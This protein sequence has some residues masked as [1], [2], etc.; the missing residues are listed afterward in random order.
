MLKELENFGAI[1]LGLSLENASLESKF[2][3][4]SL[5]FELAFKTP[6]KI[7]FDTPLNL[8]L[9]IGSSLYSTLAETTETNKTYKLNQFYADFKLE[10]PYRFDWGSFIIGVSYQRKWLKVTQADNDAQ[11]SPNDNSENLI[12]L[13][14]QFLKGITW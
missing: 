4:T 11:I 9:S 14:I 8:K 5:F 7:I 1:G 12:G 3:S 6:E 10:R 13:H 2:S